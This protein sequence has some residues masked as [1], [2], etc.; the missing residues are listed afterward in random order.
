M[1]DPGESERPCGE[2][3]MCCKLLRIDRC[4]DGC[5]LD[6]P[7]DKPGGV[8]CKHFKPGCGCTL[9]G[10]EQFPNLCKTF[11]CL[12]KVKEAAVPEEYRPDKMRVIFQSVSELPQFPGHPIARVEVDPSR[13]LD[14]RFSDWME[15]RLDSGWAVIANIGTRRLIFT[16]VPGMLQALTD[17]E[18]DE[19]AEDVER[20]R[21]LGAQI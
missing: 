4:T 10:T 19:I 18:R 17:T 14:P 16:D 1:T 7:F 13:K 8:M 5:D 20:V 21:Q 9:H 11:V 15:Y 3:G 2:C 6:F 12:W